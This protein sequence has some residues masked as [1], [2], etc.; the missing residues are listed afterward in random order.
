[1]IEPSVGS[2]RRSTVRA[3]VDLPQPL[4]PTRPRVSASPRVKL[5]SST[6]YTWPTVRRR[7]PFLT[8]KC[9]FR[10][11]TSST[12]APLPPPAP[13]GTT[14]LPVV[15]CT[16]ASTIKLLR[17][18]AG[19]PMPRA[20]LF[21]GRE[22]GPALL[23]GIGAARREGT[24]GRQIGQGRHQTRDLLQPAVRFRRGLAADDREVG[25]RGEQAV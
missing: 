19:G 4:S 15:S 5:T 14:L 10:L 7:M 20:L 3:T 6:A 17:M 21:V 23:V 8:G 16:A 2:I 1:M 12:G 18:P 25:D 22:K 13:L 11:T 9:F 24:A